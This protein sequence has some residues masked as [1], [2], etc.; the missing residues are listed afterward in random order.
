MEYM[1]R[2]SLFLDCSAIVIIVLIII[3]SAVG[4]SK[5]KSSEVK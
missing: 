2:A 4:S 5:D 1:E 3:A